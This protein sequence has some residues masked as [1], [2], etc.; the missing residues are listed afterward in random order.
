MI[1][2]EPKIVDEVKLKEKYLEFLK[3]FRDESGSRKYEDLALRAV[4][5]KKRSLVIDYGDLFANIETRDVALDLLER[6]IT[7]IRAASQ[8]VK[9]FLRTNAGPLSDDTIYFNKPFHARFSN[10]PIRVGIREI[11]SYSLGKIA[12]VEGIVTRVS[13]TY[14]RLAEAVYTCVGCGYEMSMPVEDDT[15]PKP[16]AS[17]PN[18]GQ[19][20]KFNQERSSFISWQYIRIQERPEDLP[21]GGMPKYIDATLLDDIVDE[22]K[23][24]DRI[25]TSAIINLR[26]NRKNI[27]DAVFGPLF[28]RFLEINFVETS[29]K[30]YERVVITPEDED[31]IRRLSRDPQLEERIVKSIAPSIYGHET[32]KRAI[33]LALFGGDEKILKDGTKIRGEV[34]L[35]LVGDP[36]T[37]KCITGD[38]YVLLEGDLRRVEELI[39]EY[40]PI[41]DGEDFVWR[42]EMR[43]ASLNRMM[44]ICWEKSSAIAKRRHKGDIITVKTRMGFEIKVTPTHPF[45]TIVNGKTEY[46]RASDLH[47]GFYIAV[48]GRVPKLDADRRDDLPPELIGILYYSNIKSS[49]S[50]VR[51]QIRLMNPDLMGIND[52]IPPESKLEYI[53]GNGRLSISLDH[54]DDYLKMPRQRRD[55]PSY[56]LFDEKEF[57]RLMRGIVSAAGRINRAKGTLSVPVYSRKVAMK[58]MLALISMGYRP[59][60]STKGERHSIMIKGEDVSDL[61]RRIGVRVAIAV[62]K[63]NED[64]IPGI[65]DVLIGILRLIKSKEAADLRKKL[66]KFVTSGRPVSLSIAREVVD[67]AK[68]NGISVEDVET[69][70]SSD[71][72]WDEVK[73]I[74]REEFDGWVYDIEVPSSRNFIANGLVVH[75]SQL[76]KYVSRISPRGLY[77]TGK[78]S[79]AAG[80]TAA[81][82]RDASTGGW[83]LEAGALVLADRGTACIDEFDKMSEEDRRAIHEAM[84]QQ[85]ISIAKAGIVAT[86][87]ARTTIIAA[88]NPKKGRYDKMLSVAENINLPPTILSRFDLIY[89]IKDDPSEE[90]DR[91][92]A[93]HITE[94]RRGYNPEAEP[95]IPIDLLR[96]YIAYARQNIRPVLTKEAGEEISRFYLS[97]RKMSKEKAEAVEIMEQAPIPITPRQLEALFRLSEAR[98][99]LYLREEVTA[100][101]TRVA[102]ELLKAMLKDVGYD[103][104]TGTYDVSGFMHES[105]Q[106]SSYRR[107]HIMRLLSQME[108]QYE[109]GEV[110]RAELI[111]QAAKELNMVGKE[112]IIEK[113][114][115]S[116]YESGRIYI[117]RPGYVKIVPRRE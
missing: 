78:G 69:I 44:K 30:E 92:I 4:E 33:A 68:R 48:A 29:S 91:R 28:R 22:V 10:I 88:A 1:T 70:I 116:L 61:L 17:C 19:I 7:N 14:D 45:L 56:L 8:A 18:C 103:E 55:L 76:L 58:I 113:D 93:R 59:F 57:L 43:I 112:V 25:K 63:R 82:V 111:A 79:T 72:V 102:I 65:G 75:N 64:C 107:A 81:V 37:A 114:I 6:P 24:G 95:P 23:P 84:E 36:G 52:I 74:L 108:K 35:L 89:V 83:T 62:R 5:S 9:E 87:N 96:K 71:M 54:V 94:T 41:P 49:E 80:L 42:K 99:K 34:N 117:P 110:P 90:L 21:P 105:F 85:T 3:T 13:D 60:M 15:M 32:I 73:Q 40:E 46:R 31:E 26:K 97:M 16:P 51:A 53:D 47:P 50:E 12:S 109:N 39:P 77:T 2:G 86:L 67:M 66:K 20:M 106:S 98:A 11:P 115:R 100:E 27:G 38:S 101:D 104:V